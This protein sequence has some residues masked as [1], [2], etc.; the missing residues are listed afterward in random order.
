MARGLV[1]QIG[2]ETGQTVEQ[3]QH[4]HIAIQVIAGIVQDAREDPRQPRLRHQNG[5]T[6]KAEIIGVER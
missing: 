3:G 4:A 6:A 1:D 5:A 2:M